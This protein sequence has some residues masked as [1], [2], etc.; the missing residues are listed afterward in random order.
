MANK[1]LFLY[2][3]ED[4]ARLPRRMLRRSIRGHLWVSTE[5]TDGRRLRKCWTSEKV[6]QPPYPRCAKLESVSDGLA[7][8]FV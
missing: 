8:Q 4:R 1:G 6:W 5:Q 3:N 7:V 2:S